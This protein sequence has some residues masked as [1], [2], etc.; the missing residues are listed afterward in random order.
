MARHSGPQVQYQGNI[1][2]FQILSVGGV[3]CCTDKTYQP[4]YCT[5]KLSITVDAVQYGMMYQMSF[6][7][8]HIL[9]VH[10]AYINTDN[11]IGVW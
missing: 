6:V 3:T 9:G 10:N 1:Y 4:L 2:V 7:D 8:H 5:V 11:I